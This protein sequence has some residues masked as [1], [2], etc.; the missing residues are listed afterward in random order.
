MGAHSESFPNNA[1]GSG[2]FRVVDGLSTSSQKS[3]VKP[4]KRNNG[5][6]SQGRAETARCGGGKGLGGADEPGV[7]GGF[8]GAAHRG[9]DVWNQ[10]SV[11]HRWH[12]MIGGHGAGA[13]LR[14]GMCGGEH[15]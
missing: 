5:C 2:G 1:V 4:Q 11:E 3:P 9:G 14:N 13:G 6:A 7:P 10:V 12:H 15:H 8:R